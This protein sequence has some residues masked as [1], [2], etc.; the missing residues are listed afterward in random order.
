MSL[1]LRIRTLGLTL[2]D[3]ILGVR[4]CKTAANRMLHKCRANTCAY[5]HKF[6][7]A[8]Q[9]AEMAGEVVH[10]H[11]PISSLCYASLST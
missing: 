9:A 11:S 10:D 3:A 1:C 2:L 8:I 4:P 5:A 7:T 6:Q